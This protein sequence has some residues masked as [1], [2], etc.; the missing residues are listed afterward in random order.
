M[1]MSEQGRV[2]LVDGDTGK[3]RRLGSARYCVGGRD[4]FVHEASIKQVEEPELHFVGTEQFNCEEQMQ[5]DYA[6]LFSD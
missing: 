4:G 2:E 5:N 1:T 3:E 6:Y